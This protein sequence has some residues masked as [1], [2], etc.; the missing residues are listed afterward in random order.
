MVEIHLIQLSS[1]TEIYKLG[2]GVF[3][4]CKGS[5]VSFLIQEIPKMSLKNRCK[6]HRSYDNI[7]NTGLLQVCVRVME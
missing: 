6:C 2:L 7:S 3:F 4:V 1:A 5:Q